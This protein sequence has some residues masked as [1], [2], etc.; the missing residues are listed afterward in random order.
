MHVVIVANGTMEDRAGGRMIAER[1]DML[2][3]ADGG[4]R[5][6]LEW[7]LTPDAVIGDMDSLDDDSL[8]RLALAGVEL[9]RHPPRKDAT[10]LELALEWAIDR[11]ATEITILGALGGRI[12]QTLGNIM[13]LAHPRLAG[14]AVRIQGDGER[15]MPV[16]EGA[17]IRG[18]PG[19]TVSLLPLTLEVTHVTTNGLEYPLRSETLHR[20]SS[21]GISNRLI[22]KEATVTVGV[23]LLLLIHHAGL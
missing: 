23:G 17:T 13:L 4:A 14:I 3:C 22:D 11:G 10:D 12:D 5:Y 8:D 2:L 19:D 15:L 1:A 6:A 7:G 9:V 16:R 20:S 21:R 18:R